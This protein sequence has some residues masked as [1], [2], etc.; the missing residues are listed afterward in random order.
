MEK[1]KLYWPKV[2]TVQSGW[3]RFF[4]KHE[5]WRKLKRTNYKQ[6]IIHLSKLL[7]FIFRKSHYVTFL[8]SDWKVPYQYSCLWI[9][10]R[11]KSFLELHVHF[12]GFMCLRMRKCMQNARF[13][14]MH[15]IEAK[16]CCHLVFQM[17]FR[18]IQRQKSYRNFL[19]DRSE[20]W[21]CIYTLFITYVSNVFKQALKFNGATSYKMHAAFIT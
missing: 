7:K 5:L 13:K 15:V 16:L 12:D 3:S 10:F 8:A 17:S 6:V 14:P 4:R 11:L 21:P 18:N 20:L 1:N 9:K 19:G 2:L